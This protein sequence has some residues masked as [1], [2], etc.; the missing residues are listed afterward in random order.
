MDFKS[1]V[2]K[3]KELVQEKNNLNQNP[4]EE[5]MQ[6]VSDDLYIV[7]LEKE[8]LPE[9]VNGSNGD[10]EDLALLFSLKQD[11]LYLFHSWDRNVEAVLSAAGYLCGKYQ[12]LCDFVVDKIKFRKNMSSPGISNY[13]YLWCLTIASLS[14]PEAMKQITNLNNLWNRYSDGPR[15]GRSDLT[16]EEEKLGQN[17]LPDAITG[18]WDARKKY[19]IYGSASQ[20][21]IKILI[22]LFGEDPSAVS[23]YVYISSALFLF[24]GERNIVTCLEVNSPFGAPVNVEKDFTED[25]I[26]LFRKNPPYYLWGPSFEYYPRFLKRWS[27]NSPVFRRELSRS[28]DFILPVFLKRHLFAQVSRGKQEREKRVYD[29]L[30]GRGT[31][32]IEGF[33]MREDVTFH[34]LIF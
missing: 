30:E 15:S 23:A 28:V 9:F 5:V 24:L 29:S 6:K 16:A 1:Y 14:N 10:F 17:L 3:I 4:G 7:N 22:E 2:S 31:E 32:E 12:N 19:Y 34:S 21:S 13:T 25:V 20:A 26:S 33:Y 18:H 27:E 8:Y 11:L